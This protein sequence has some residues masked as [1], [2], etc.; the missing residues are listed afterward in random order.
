MSTL[1]SCA[2]AMLTDCG[3]RRHLRNESWRGKYSALLD[4]KQPDTGCYSNAITSRKDKTK[5]QKEFRI[6]ARE[7]A[8]EEIENVSGA[9]GVVETVTELGEAGSGCTMPDESSWFKM[10]N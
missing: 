1:C 9:E 4:S 3:P 6:L 10:L 5:M 7:L 8:V 2:P